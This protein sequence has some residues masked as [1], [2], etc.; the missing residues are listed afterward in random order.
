MPHVQRQL[1]ESAAGFAAR[2]RFILEA[3]GSATPADEAEAMR[4]VSLS[5]VWANQR[6]L[7]CKYPQAVA[8]LVGVGAATGPGPGRGAE[9]MLAFEGERR[10]KA[11]MAALHL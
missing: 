1:W 6:L 4:Q 3:F 10:T 9:G 11:A 8:S 5:M 7:K 2:V